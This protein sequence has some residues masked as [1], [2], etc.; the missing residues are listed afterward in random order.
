MLLDGTL[1]PIQ[2]A[3][4]AVCAVVCFLAGAILFRR[5]SPTLSDHL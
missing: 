2:L 4:P 1:N 3:W 5:L